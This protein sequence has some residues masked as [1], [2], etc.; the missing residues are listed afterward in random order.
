MILLCVCQTRLLLG[1]NFC[2][3]E[4]NSLEVNLVLFM[5]AGYEDA[6]MQQ[7]SVK[8]SAIAFSLLCGEQSLERTELEYFNIT[9][10][11]SV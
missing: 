6:D 4:L 2:S 1:M 5:H 10:I 11:F 9:A 3:P 7:P 8:W